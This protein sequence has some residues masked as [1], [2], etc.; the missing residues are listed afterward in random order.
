MRRFAAACMVVALLSAACGDDGSDAAP[1]TT[2]ATPTTSS[3]TTTSTTTTS[4]TTTGAVASTTVDP[5]TTLRPQCA[6]VP[7]EARTLVDDSRVTP[8]TAESDEL[9][10]RTIDVWIDRPALAVASPLLI[11]AHGLTGHPRSHEMHRQYLAEECFVVV[12][13]AFPL[14]N[15]DVPGGFLNAGDTENQVGDVSFLIDQ[16]LADPEL[17]PLVDPDHIG[18][19]GH[20][21]GGLTTAGAALSPDGDLRVSAAV[22]MSAGFGEARDDVAVMVMHGDA[23]QVVPYASSDVSYDVLTGHRMLVTLLGGNHLEGI[24][25]DDSELGP[26]VRGLT[27]AFFSYELDADPGTVEELFELPLELVTIEAGS[28][29]GAIDDWRDYF[30]SGR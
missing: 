24:I 15:E 4:T 11:F 9:P 26:V 14:T 30:A 19:I 28:P 1:A 18:V 27:G 2:T 3:T 21:L 10:A 17:G 12:A 13:P 16:I 7:T 8:A 6:V 25:D 29:D 23:D 22:V 5:A 20:S